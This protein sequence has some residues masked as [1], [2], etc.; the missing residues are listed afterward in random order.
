LQWEM[1]AFTRFM[2]N[3]L[4]KRFEKKYERTTLYMK[5]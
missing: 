2:E 5:S 3:H 4:I 1:E